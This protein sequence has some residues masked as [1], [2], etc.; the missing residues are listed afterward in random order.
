MSGFIDSV[1]IELES[2]RG[3]DG[4]AT[5]HREK[6]VPRGGPNGSDGGRGGDVV[7]V[8]DRH[9]RTLYDFKFTDRY[10]AQD[11]TKA[12]LNKRGKD[13]ADTVIQ[14]PVGTIVQDAATGEVL[15]DLC[16][17]GM[18]FVVCEGGRGGQGNVHFTNSV[19]QAPTF[20]QKGGPAESHSIQLELKLLADVALIGLPNAGK[21]T[22]LSVLSAARPKIAD[23]P[24][25]TLSPNL[26]VVKV[27][28]RTFVMADLPGLIE[29]ASEGI[30]LGHQFLKHA[31]RNRVLLHLV[32]AF[33]IDETD[34]YDNYR[35]IEDEL[36]QYSADLF[37]LPRIVA[38]TKLDTAPSSEA[39]ER[40]AARFA[41]VSLH[42]ISAV[43]GLGMT[44][45]SRELL[46]TI[47]EETEA[48]ESVRLVPVLRPAKEERYEVSKDNWGYHVAGRRVEQLVA[49]TDLGNSEAVMYLHRMLQRIG[50]IQQLRGLGIE[51]GDEVRVGSFTF[52]YK[53]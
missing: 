2:G 22:L 19:R 38:L 18:R 34:P 9:K 37:A 36:R 49:M 8:A 33:P 41:E 51:D 29:G 32:E 17:D 25:T 1:R 43:T 13:G 47:D 15:V 4:A 45:L 21:S 39:V 35:L 50:V 48:Q 11:G 23:Y 31:E 26:G 28:D 42:R 46:D 10:K 40:V 12:V 5:F 53:D 14:L 20:A 24:F 30:G 6:H 7:L 16:H 27:G 52:T 44:E 3:G